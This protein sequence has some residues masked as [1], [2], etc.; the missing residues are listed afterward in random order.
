M[1]SIWPDINVIIIRNR[2]KA[3]KIRKAAAV[4]FAETLMELIRLKKRS[5]EIRKM[6]TSEAE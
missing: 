4:K 1:G 6:K 3:P 2:K 5:Y